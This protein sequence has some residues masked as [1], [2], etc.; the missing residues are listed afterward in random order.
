M[1]I[2][3]LFFPPHHFSG[4]ECV[5]VSRQQSW[6]QEE[7][8][9][10]LLRMRGVSC[11]TLMMYICSYKVSLNSYTL[12]VFVLCVFPII[13]V[14]LICLVRCAI[15]TNKQTKNWQKVTPWLFAVQKWMGK[16]LTQQLFLMCK[17]VY[18]N[19]LNEHAQ[20][21]RGDSQPPTHT[22]TQTERE[23]NNWATVAVW[24]T[25]YIHQ[26]LIWRGADFH[27]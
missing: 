22:V 15:W 18:I 7:K 14:F 8:P 3:I 19:M 25:A 2:I 10:L 1:H 27:I 11:W 9:V 17:N 4:N 21:W 12:L 5:R 13:M 16:T 26:T 23:W 6:H 24:L 20:K